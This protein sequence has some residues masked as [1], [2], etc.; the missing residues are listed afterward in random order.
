MSV[1]AVWLAYIETMA[2]DSNTEPS[3]NAVLVFTKV[4][5][6]GKVKTRLIPAL[7]AEGAT[8]LYRRLL[9]RQIH[10]LANET[11]YAIQLWISSLE[12]HPL[13]Q[14]LV[15]DCGLTLHCQQG[16]DL[17]ERMHQAAIT[18]LQKYQKVVLL[19]V[20]CPALTAD[21]LQ[22]TFNWLEREDAVLGPAQDGGYVLLGLKA[23]APSLFKEHNWGAADVAETTRAALRGLEWRWCELPVLWDLDR[24][25]DLI[26]LKT[27][28]IEV[29]GQDLL[30]G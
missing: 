23:V 20:D 1:Q 3:T 18:A 11:N 27:L 16:K 8:E 2:T 22:Q 14:K 29:D 5:E 9:D 7:G 10:W 13:I 25:E 30:V 28:G 12:E 24:P 17:G 21:H 4:P 26:Q 6:V 15:E 19:G